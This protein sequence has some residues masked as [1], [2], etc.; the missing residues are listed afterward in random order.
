MVTPVLRQPHKDSKILVR[1]AHGTLAALTHHRYTDYS[2]DVVGPDGETYTS[3]PTMVVGKIKLS[4][5]LEDPP[6]K[7]TLPS[8][9]FTDRLAGGYAHAPVAVTVFEVLEDQ[10]RSSKEALV[11]FMGK[12]SRTRKNPSGAAGQVEIEAKNHKADL[13]VP[14]GIVIGNQ[15]PWTFGDRGC[16]I[17]AIALAETGTVDSIDRKSLTLA[18]PPATITPDKY[19]HRGYVELNGLRIGIRD[20]SAATSHV[21]QLVRDVPPDWLN[22]DVTIVP[23]CAKTYEDC[24]VKWSNAARFGGA[25]FAIPPYHPVFEDFA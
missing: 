16:G 23:G 17:D 6:V 7:I 24:N 10:G 21:F 1:F 19:W 18:S 5:A 15:C 2:S 3:T 9:S 14:L 8:D 12:V 25:G 13:D 22:E 4:G 20:W 11:L